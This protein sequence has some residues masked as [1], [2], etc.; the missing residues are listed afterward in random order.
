MDCFW[1]AHLATCQ[2]IKLGCKPETATVISSDVRGI[3]TAAEG[4]TS[5]LLGIVGVVLLLITAAGVIIYTRRDSDMSPDP[6]RSKHGDDPASSVSSSATGETADDPDTGKLGR[7]NTGVEH[8]SSANSPEVVFEDRIGQRTLDRLEP[9]V[10]D[11][12]KQVRDR[13]PFENPTTSDPVGAIERDLQR[14]IE[15][16]LDTG[17]FDPVVTSS[18]GRVYKIVN[19]PAQFRE[20]TVP[21]ENKTVHVANIETVVRETLEDSGL[22]ETGR[23][24]AAVHD[25]CEEIESFVR[26]QEELYLDERREVNDM[27]ADIR[28]MTDRFDGDLGARLREFV[29]DGRNNALP[30]TVDI[31]RQLDMADESL[32]DCAFDDA[33]RVVNEARQASDDLLIVLDFLNGAT[34]TIEHGTGRVAIPDDVDD[35]FI[36]DLVPI[37][38]RQHTSPVT[39]DG[40]QLIVTGG[41]GRSDDTGR[42]GPEPG[43]KSRGIISGSESSAN[44]PPSPS[45]SRQDRRDSPGEEQLTPSAAADEILYILRELDGREGS[46]TVECQTERLPE[47]VARHEVLKPLARFCRR[48]TEIVASVTLQENAPPGFFEIQFNEGTSASAGLSLLRERFIQRHAT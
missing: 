10:P 11:T 40:N 3:I 24:V 43:A 44:S 39:L 17:Q 25:H 28:Q 21:P 37:L 15:T 5:I 2:Q 18:L 38:D 14:A 7:L 48:Q 29:I 16:A 19:L 12:T 6:L 23:T 36:T 4:F 45:V 27:L 22:R 33:V 34:G 46:Q 20:L 1:K 31:E 13:L 32:H 42:S 30:G 26:R 9:V 41:S 8:D 35:S 47:T